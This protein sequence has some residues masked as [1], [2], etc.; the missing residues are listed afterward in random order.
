[1]MALAHDEGWL[2]TLPYTRKE[3]T[4]WWRMHHDDTVQ[5]QILNQLAP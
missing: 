5:T 4:L 2:L 1:M 3:D